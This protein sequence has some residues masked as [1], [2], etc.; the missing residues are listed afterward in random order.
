M[1]TITQEAVWAAYIASIGKRTPLQAAH[2]AAELCRLAKS[3]S[4]L[5]EIACSCGLTEWQERRKQNLQNRIK[6][7]LERVQVEVHARVINDEEQDRETASYACELLERLAS[8]AANRC[9]R[10]GQTMVQ[11]IRLRGGTGTA[12]VV[13]LPGAGIGP[14]QCPGKE[15]QKRWLPKFSSI[16]FEGPWAA[17]R[18]CG[19]QSEGSRGVRP[20]VTSGRVTEEHVEQRVPNGGRWFLVG[21][22]VRSKGGEAA[23]R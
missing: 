5:N 2:D 20:N 16:G 6:A 7:V 21:R 23:D 12:E 3:L 15:W 11:V 10:N 9:F 17:A 13:K 18:K 8:L 4:R 14:K 22:R 1:R 19:Q